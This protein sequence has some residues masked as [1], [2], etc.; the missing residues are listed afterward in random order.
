MVTNNEVSEEDAKEI[1]KQGCFP[2]QKQWN[3]N[4]IC[5]AVTW[6]RSKYTILGKR[7]DGSE[8]EG[9]YLT[10]KPV[11]KDKQRKVQQIGFTSIDDLKIAARKKQLVALID[12]IPQSEVKKDSA[13]VV[14]EKHPASILFDDSQA[15]AWLEALEDQEH[16]TDF[17]IIS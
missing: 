11:E 13:F 9:E 1:T 16:I 7:D 6:P 17:Y 12:G 14:S 4:G 8:L 5:Q 2:G 15:D 3:S 10:S